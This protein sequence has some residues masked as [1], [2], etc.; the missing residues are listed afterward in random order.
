[1]QC[2][3]CGTHGTGTI[4]PA[5]N[6]SNAVRTGFNP[7][8]NGCMPESVVR[9][10][11]PDYP[12]RWAQS[13]ISGDTSQSDWNLCS[14]CMGKLHTYLKPLERTG[15]AGTGESAGSSVAQP[16]ATITATAPSESWFKKLFT[17][18]AKHATN[19]KSHSGTPGT[20]P[21]NREKDPRPSTASDP[22]A[23]KIFERGPEGS[24]RE[25]KGR[26]DMIPVLFQ[27]A[28]EKYQRVLAAAR[29]NH[30]TSADE[31]ELLACIGLLDKV[32]ELGPTIGGEPYSLRAAMFF[33]YGQINRDTT[34]L[35]KAESDYRKAIEVGTRDPEN[36]SIW[37]NS[38]EQICIVRG[39]V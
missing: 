7:F 20:G 4:V 30:V 31:Q 15:S 35:D 5:R 2:D 27:Q 19:G 9:M 22:H 3:I 24:L 33:V 34:A 32:I 37:R 14:S 13:A 39:I 6:F 11:S 10:A 16:P 18:A 23:V 8:Y 1:M 25:S 17:R 26:E 29:A 28:H 38:I 36:P 21:S 12:E